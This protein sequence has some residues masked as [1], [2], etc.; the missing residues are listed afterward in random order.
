M[1]L[2]ILVA[3]MALALA[4]CADSSVQAQADPPPLGPVDEHGRQPLRIGKLVKKRLIA[5]VMSVA[6][7]DWLTRPERDAEEQPDRV[8]RE[9]EIAPGST[10]AESWPHQN[11]RG[12]RE[13]GQ[14]PVRAGNRVVI[15]I[16]ETLPGERVGEYQEG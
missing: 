15:I 9:L 10:V 14:Y 6:H 8:V 3:V 16:K 1:K 5:P 11:A 4:G 13:R 7:A 12:R 2:T